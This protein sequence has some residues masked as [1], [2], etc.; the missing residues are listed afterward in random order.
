MMIAEVSKKYELTQDTLRYYERIGLIPNVN[1]NKS[2]IRDYTDEDC[3]WISFV[4]CMRN[5]GLQIEVLTK[6]LDLFQQ[7]KSTHD[8]RKGLLVKQRDLLAKKIEEMQE[9]LERLN[10]KIENYDQRLMA[11][12][13]ELLNQGNSDTDIK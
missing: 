7:G 2:G 5:A 3:K 6:Y 12:E 1:R 8:E 13:L 10:Y 4:K 9:T 11:K